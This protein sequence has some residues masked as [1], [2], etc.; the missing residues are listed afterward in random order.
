MIKKFEV[1]KGYIG[2]STLDAKRQRVFVCVER[3]GNEIVFTQA[4]DIAKVRP[5]AI[6]GRETALIGSKDGFDYMVSPHVEA[7]LGDAAAVVAAMFAGAL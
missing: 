6:V 7:K 4:T 3:V 1:G 5:E 2:T